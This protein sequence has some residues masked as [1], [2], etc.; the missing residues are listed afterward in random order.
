MFVSH[1][2]NFEDVMLW[3]A[4]GGVTAG[5]YIDI[6][7]QHPQFDS[8]SK[9]F[10]DHGWRG[11]HVE[12]LPIYAELLRKERPDELVLQAAVSD[13]PGALK[14]FEIPDTGISTGDEDI[15]RQHSARGFASKEIVVPT[16]TLADVLS[17][18]VNGIVHWM[19]IDV[20]GMEDRVLKGW[21]ECA[22]RP[23]LVVVESTL[24]LTQTEQ[25]SKWEHYLLDRGYKY[26]YF[27]GLNR[28]YVHEHH[29]ELESAFRSGP[30]VFDGFAL[31]GTSSAP[32]CALMQEQQRQLSQSH[33]HEQAALRG[34]LAAREL[35][36]LADLAAT[37]DSEI[38]SSAQAKQRYDALNDQLTL[39]AQDLGRANAELANTRSTITS[40]L[41]T[42]NQL[43]QREQDLIARL[44]A[45]ND[46]QISTEQQA[47][48]RQQQ[49]LAQLAAAQ[50]EWLAKA[51][52]AHARELSIALAANQARA[53]FQ[54]RL[55]QSHHDLL[56]IRD[57]SSLRERALAEALKDTQQDSLKLMHSKVDRE[58]ALSKIIE[59]LEARLNHTQSLAAGR[60]AELLENVQQLEISHTESRNLLQVRGDTLAAALET[61]GQLTA[62]ADALR[63]SLSN[64]EHQNREVR[65]ILGV[66]R[67]RVSALE[68][69][70]S[71]RMT[72][73]VRVVA[74]VL[75]PRELSRAAVIAQPR[76]TSLG[77]DALIVAMR[78]VFRHPRLH[79]F[80]LSILRNTPG[81]YRR[82]V[83]FGTLN[84]ALPV[85]TPFIAVSA[86]MPEATLTARKPA[87][88]V[89]GSALN[90]PQFAHVD[91]SFVGEA[92]SPA[93]I[94]TGMQT[95]VRLAGWPVGRRINA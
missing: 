31:A 56:R 3:R 87:D 72:K 34:T 46:E 85:A 68:N 78:Y 33:E 47:G 94:D 4:L 84:R 73:P 60:E 13:A 50:A 90:A 17:L 67:A 88:A 53:E 58:L 12:A 64:A 41:D 91:N 30:N 44:L 10:Y 27:D 22:I 82:L 55:S 65:G 70:W 6:G 83:D 26:C 43:S 38:G 57:A 61:A 69:S 76:R 81:L 16:I 66:E 25:H 63:S 75:Q 51:E 86:H 59:D 21:A 2:Q 11:I 95:D 29:A 92:L 37:R 28:F 62:T 18:A 20:E 36:A 93:S 77:S 8:V 9:A 24:P 49:L 23:W 32:F 1:A 71:W 7:A 52:S 35:Q 54:V 15:A 14:F 48:S 79:Q 40:L 5:T 19:K 89:L 74:A 80:S 45:A 42:Q 39:V